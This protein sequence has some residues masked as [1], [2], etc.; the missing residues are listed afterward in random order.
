MELAFIRQRIGLSRSTWPEERGNVL[1]IQILPDG[2]EF[3]DRSSDDATAM[4]LD[5][6]SMRLLEK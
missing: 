4:L 1:L 6:S 5:V 2:E 3:T